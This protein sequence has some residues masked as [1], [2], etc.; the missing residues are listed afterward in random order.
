MGA[1]IDLLDVT[2]EVSMRRLSESHAHRALVRFL[3]KVIR[4]F[5]GVL[6]LTL[7]AIALNLCAFLLVVAIAVVFIVCR[8]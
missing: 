8:D 1:L 3:A 2:D 4:V 6:L 7:V 5:F